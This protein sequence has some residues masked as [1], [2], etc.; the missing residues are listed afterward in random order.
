MFA[1]GAMM[2]PSAA[3]A[4]EAVNRAPKAAV[5]APLPQGTHPRIAAELLAMVERD[6]EVR[7]R[8]EAS[9]DSKSIMA[10][11]IAL[12]AQHEPRIN[13]ILAKIGWPGV[14]AVGPQGNQAMWLLVQHAS[15]KLLKQSLPAMRKA[16]QEGELPW[17]TVA[18]SIDRDLLNDGKKQL[19]GSQLIRDDAGK[20]V[21]RPVED[22]SR[23][24]ERRAKVGLE[25]IAAYLRRFEAP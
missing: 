14:K 3:L 13:A 5:A 7:R 10:E 24:D 17:S 11:M 19:Y 21:L 8:Y 9:P 18:L 15:P 25:P 1:L 20:L 6:Q 23:L 2:A 22:E 16:A 12:D 4:G